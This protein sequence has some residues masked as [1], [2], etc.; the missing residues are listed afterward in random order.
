MIGRALILS[1]LLL[2]SGRAL[3]LSTEAVPRWALEKLNE[4][5]AGTVTSQ[6]VRFD[7]ETGLTL[8]GVRVT[9]PN[10][11]LVLQAQRITA[12]VSIGKL[13][14]DIVSIDAIEITGLKASLRESKDG[15]FDLVEAFM[16][17][18]KSVSDGE[19]SGGGVRIQRLSINNSEFELR[20]PSASLVIRDLNI[21]GRLSVVDTLT[22][23]L[24]LNSGAITFR[25]PARGEAN[26]STVFRG[27]IVKE[28]RLDDQ[29]IRIG[30]GSLRV[31]TDHRLA[32][33]G[34]VNTGADRIALD[35]DGR[36][37]PRWLN[38]SLGAGESIPPMGA[39]QTQ[40]RI[41]GAMS[42]PTVEF[43]LST[44]NVVLPSGAPRL[45]T[46]AAQGKYT[47]TKLFLSQVEA[48]TLGGSVKMSG[49]MAM[50][51]RF[52]SRLKGRLS[53]ISL[54]AAEES[55]TPY[56]GR[57]T[58]MVTLQGPMLFS[59][60][61]PLSIQLDGQVDGFQIPSIGRR[62]VLVRGG[63]LQGDSILLQPTTLKTGRSTA[64]VEGP[65]YPRLALGWSLQST[66]LKRL[67]SALDVND[68]LPQRVTA[69]GRLVLEP[70]FR[71]SFSLNAGR[72]ELFDMPFGPTR[73][74]GIMTDDLLVLKQLKSTL[75]K[76]QV[77]SE[78]LT[79]RLNDPTSMKGDLNVIQMMLP[80]IEG[81][82]TLELKSPDFD[83]WN[84]DLLVEDIVA[85][86]MA[87]GNLDTNLRF[88]GKRLDLRF[89][90]W[91]DGLGVLNGS[92]G[93][94]LA[95]NRPDGSLSLYLDQT[96]LQMLGSDILEGRAKLLLQPKGT[97]DQIAARA[98]LEMD[99]LRVAGVP[100]GQGQMEFAATPNHLG[101][102]IKLRGNG[103]AQGS[104]R[105]TNNFE[106]LDLQ[107]QWS[108][109]EIASLP[110]GIND[111]RGKVDLHTRL[112]GPL[113]APLGEANLRLRHLRIGGQPLGTG[114]GGL[115]LVLDPNRLQ[116]DLELIGWL[117]GTLVS[118]WPNLE[119]MDLTAE[120]NANTLEDLAPTLR[121]TGSTASLGA[122]L[123]LLRRRG[124]PSGQ[125]MIHRLQVSNP[126]LPGQELENA[127]DIILGYG[128]GRVR[129][130]KM[131][132]KMAN[133]QLSVQGFVEPEEDDGRV[134]LRVE[135]AFPMEVLQALDPG[136]SLA[137]GRIALQGLARGQLY[138][139]PSIQVKV[140]PEPGT[141][142]IHSTYPRPLTIL[143]G[144]IE[145]DQ[146]K[147]SVQDLR[148]KSG[149]GEL[150]LDGFVTLEDL[151]PQAAEVNLSMN[152]FRYRFGKNFLEIN[153]DLKASGPLIGAKIN[154]NVHLVRGKIE[155]K[156][157]LTTLVLSNRVEGSGQSLRDLL[158]AYSDTE[159]D[160]QVTSSEE[161]FIQAGL[162]V[163]AAELTP[164]IDLKVGGL[165]AEPEISGVLE[166]DEG[167]GAI[168]FPKAR[169]IVDSASVDLSQ[170]P[171]F[172][173]LDATWDYVPRRRSSD[174]DEIITLKLG[175]S[176]P[177][178][179]VAIKLAAPDFP[180]ITD[181]QL[182]AMLA[183]GQTPDHLVN[184][185]T[186]DE[187]DGELGSIALKMFAGQIIS[188]FERNLELVL[189]SALQMPTEVTIDPGVERLRME[190]VIQPINRLEVIGET[191]LLFSNDDEVTETQT[192][193]Q[194]E[195]SSSRQAI[196]TT[197][198]I[199]D[200]LRAEAN[201]RN[202]FITDEDGSQVLELL[203]NLRWRLFQR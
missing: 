128:G 74:Q 58:G 104:V 115:R 107:L 52:E 1:A 16:P 8:T 41:R 134:N 149:S 25:Q 131:G 135:G 146:K 96:G 32:L 98:V 163:L 68:Y 102:I 33:S 63:I 153:S 2:P 186:S 97:M 166:V 140:Q 136:F 175:L 116:A 171:F 188:V 5:L 77:Q 142:I 161:V 150:R 129:V 67:L 181:A 75:S 148:I 35:F 189:N 162:P 37:P 55:M 182:L 51:D 118:G 105:L 26:L 138:D 28:L 66:R 110:T 14:A 133:G 15:N 89:R 156:V 141:T 31:D 7:T 94:E 49:T 93:F 120:L 143:S 125:V 6:G 4:S 11:R 100:L 36:I 85:G 174:Q 198:V 191:E 173:A 123:R 90:D 187:S 199:S 179:E 43:E 122:K 81:K 57:Y 65:I 185:S 103:R 196:R 13:L 64:K 48:A 158:G 170:D 168:I 176:G 59:D 172:I 18:Q 200:R 30:K 139:N 192:N 106:Q 178:D 112:T 9:A 76:G 82:A 79:M 124:V 121:M 88:D 24:R 21:F 61:H 117:N 180:E 152:A 46:F 147:A 70:R 42:D 19:K 119:N 165:L 3:A 190:A 169:F 83:Q 78:Q 71:L 45:S 154:G 155:E 177:V 145:A 159:L 84:G 23:R 113:T 10:G 183:Q 132:I 12:E 108:G 62:D 160:L 38:R 157:D 167:Q 95:T 127:G 60:T 73:T 56:G 44:T 201:L 40:G 69:S 86:G 101:G 34:K 194:T 130:E 17:R 193:S 22:A 144:Q 20:V 53:N 39:I 126:V 137:R 151:A 29:H 109:L 92:L 164:S 203:L 47:S 111:L 114:N 202:G 87:L 80:G 54:A 27:I 184:Q 91:E 197:Y 99:G 50:D 195:G 72:F